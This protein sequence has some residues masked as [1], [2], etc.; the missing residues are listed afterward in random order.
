VPYNYL[1]NN[2]FIKKVIMLGS[3]EARKLEGLEVRRLELIQPINPSIRAAFQPSSFPAFY[4]IWCYC[5]A[6][7]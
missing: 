6:F 5:M 3:Q 1:S 4:P 2:G 7:V